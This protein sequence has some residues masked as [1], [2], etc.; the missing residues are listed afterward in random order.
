M[1]D[2]PECDKLAKCAGE[3]DT[4]MEF[5]DWLTTNG[6]VIGSYYKVEGYADEQL[7][8]TSRRSD[9]LILDSL[10]ID[11]DKLENERRTMLAEIS[12]TVTKEISE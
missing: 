8:P 10:G 11:D 9:S 7:L 5:L 2:Y 4:I 3:R 6:Y 1:A 12:D